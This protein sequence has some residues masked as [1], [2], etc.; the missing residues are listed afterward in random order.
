[1]FPDFVLTEKKTKQNNNR[2]KKHSSISKMVKEV[3]ELDDLKA[4]IADAEKENKLL[5]VDF[6][7]TWCG[8]CRRIAPIITEMAEEMK[9]MCTFAKVDCDKA[10]DIN[11]SYG[12][13][14]RWDQSKAGSMNLDYVL[15][16]E[17]LRV[18][19]DYGYLWDS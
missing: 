3:V 10:Q 17:C 1:M 4:M 7:A 8:P 16:M 11:E 12:I 2:T 13:A 19:E 15:T 14:V 18:G 9:D 5:I 6:Y